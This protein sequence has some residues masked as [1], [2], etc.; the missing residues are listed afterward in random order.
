MRTS[1]SSLALAAVLLAACSGADNPPAE[2]DPPAAA[3]LTQGAIGPE[4]AEVHAYLGRYGYLPD[5]TLEQ[6]H[7]GARPLIAEAPRHADLYD[8]QTAAAVAE[9]QRRAGLPATGVVDA[10][11][12]KRIRMPRCEHPD[13]L[14][15]VGEGALQDAA[16]HAAHADHETAATALHATGAA[17]DGDSGRARPLFSLPS[18]SP[19]WDKR[20]SRRG[21]RRHRRATSRSMSTP[22]SAAP[23]AWTASSTTWTARCS[24]RSATHWAW[25]TRRCRTHR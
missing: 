14:P 25:G 22:T 9:V 13:H 5:A 16:G 17:A 21:P 3:P 15:A 2:G 20:R 12:R 1:C 19:R 24:T 8:A 23:T 6:Q 11:T 4:V 7:P 10:M 18:G